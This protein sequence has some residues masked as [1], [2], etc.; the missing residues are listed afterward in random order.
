MPVTIPPAVMV[1]A[2]VPLVMDQVPPAVPFVKAAVEAPTQITAAPPAIAGT[3]GTV[4]MVRGLVT[5]VVPQA[6][7]T[8]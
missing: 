7:V 2:P 3:T 5:V 8:E 6:L 4:V 1:A